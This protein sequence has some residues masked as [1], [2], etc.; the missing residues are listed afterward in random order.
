[1]V[2]VDWVVGEVTDGCELVVMVVGTAVT[3]RVGV[4][5]GVTIIVVTV[6]TGVI[7]PQPVDTKEASKKAIETKHI[8]I[9]ILIYIHKVN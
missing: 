9:R 5:A 8:R 4:V 2:T 7:R 6:I 3:V 1:V